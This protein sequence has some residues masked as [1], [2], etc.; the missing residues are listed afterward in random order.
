LEPQISAIS[1]HLCSIRVSPAQEPRLKPS[2][3][4]RVVIIAREQVAVDVDWGK[5]P[6]TGFT[7][8]QMDAVLQELWQQ[9]KAAY[10]GPPPPGY[11][12]PAPP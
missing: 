12:A 2:H 10:A 6:A 8:E 5:M 11:A 7:N 9:G 3:R 4:L 1:P